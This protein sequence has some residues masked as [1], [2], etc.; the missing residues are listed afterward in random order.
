VLTPLQKLPSIEVVNAQFQPAGLRML[1]KTGWL[2]TATA[3][4]IPRDNSPVVIPLHRC[5]AYIEFVGIGTKTKFER[6]EFTQQGNPLP[7]QLV[8][9]GSGIAQIKANN[10]GF[11]FIPKGNETVKIELRLAPDGAAKAISV[12]ITL[13]PN[14]SQ[15]VWFFPEERA[16]G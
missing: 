10:N 6:M 14:V 1:S 15:V 12:P 5:E 16:K 3:Y 4:V 7:S 8:F 13:T 11:P 2:F 9:K